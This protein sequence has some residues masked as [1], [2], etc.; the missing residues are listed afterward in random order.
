MPP[1]GKVIVGELMLP[2]DPEPTIEYK[3]IS[4]LD[5]IMFIT[6]GGRERTEKQYEILGKRAGF[7]RFQVVSRAFSI[8]GVMEF[9]R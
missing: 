2:E 5:N 1:N 4:I 8:M 6:P 3:N 9:H 7:S